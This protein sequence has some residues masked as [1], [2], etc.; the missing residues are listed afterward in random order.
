MNCCLEQLP[1]RDDGTP[2]VKLADNKLMDVL[3]N[4]V[5]KSWQGEV[6]RQHFYCMAKGQTKFIR[7]CENLEMLDPMK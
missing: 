3:K 7:F 1:P 5:P 6:R 4:A 2:Q